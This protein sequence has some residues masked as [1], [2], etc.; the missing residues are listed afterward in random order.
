MSEKYE[1]IMGHVT[2][3]E[4]MRGRL[5]Q[6]LD[7]ADAPSAAKIIRVPRYRRY[8][9]LAACFLALLIGALTLPKLLRQPAAPETP[10]SDLQGVPG[11]ETY[12]SASALS[13]ALGFPISGITGLPFEVAQTEYVCV[14]TGLGEIDY[15]GENGQTAVYRKSA[16]TD[17]NSGNYE[18]FS[19]VQQLSV[20]SIRATL[21]GDGTQF[22]LA[23]WTDGTYAYSVVLSDGV[24]EEVWSGIIRSAS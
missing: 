18:T 17:D 19:A 23:Y 12:L 4:A 7:S 5:L 2:V 20:G 8:A 21:K 22:T 9:A 14:W 16:G 13:E 15:T 3:T 1:Q 10:T 11:T 6:S 24:R